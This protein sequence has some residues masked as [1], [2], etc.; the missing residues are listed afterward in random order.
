MGDNLVR[1]NELV[2]KIAFVQ[3]DNQNDSI[4]WVLSKQ[5]AFSV[6]SMYR[7]L[8]NQ[9]SL[10]LNKT[11]WKLRLPLKIKIFNWLVLKGVILTKDNLLK[12]RWKGD[13][14]CCFCNNKETIQHLFFDYHVARFVWRIFTMAFGLHAPKN[15]SNFFGTWFTL[16]DQHL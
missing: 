15:V 9:I 3:L 7:Y 11:L 8:V 13:D 5:G 12:K 6:K 10:P 1:W 16:L 4:N 14:Q 2:A